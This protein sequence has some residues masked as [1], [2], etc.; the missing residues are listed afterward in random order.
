MQVAPPPGCA[1]PY[2]FFSILT[3]MD[4]STGSP[5]PPPGPASP[6]TR[7]MVNGWLINCPGRSSSALSRSMIKVANRA[8]HAH[9]GTLLE[10][11]RE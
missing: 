1:Q 5:T 4:T 3:I 10:S 7:V 11:T 9:V 6:A 8:A 2:L